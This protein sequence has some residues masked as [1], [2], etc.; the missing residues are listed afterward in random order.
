GTVTY[1][2]PDDARQRISALTGKALAQVPTSV[3]KKDIVAQFQK[4][5]EPPIIHLELTGLEVDVMGAKLKFTRVVL[6]INA[7]PSENSKYT[8]EEM[9]AL[10][11]NWAKQINAGRP[12]R[13]I[14]ARMNRAING[15]ED[16]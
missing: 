6:D 8:K 1:Q 7:R 11:T 9:E 5:T 3:T 10:F 4:A 15:E 14:I 12:R 13:G 16:Q 2:I